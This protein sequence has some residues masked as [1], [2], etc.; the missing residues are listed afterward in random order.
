MA[1]VRTFKL[2]APSGDIGVEALGSS[3]RL[4]V[5]LRCSLAEVLQ[6]ACSSPVCQR[7][8]A[9]LGRHVSGPGAAP[10]WRQAAHPHEY[11]QVTC[12]TPGRW[13]QQ[14]Q[15]QQEAAQPR[16]RALASDS[17]DLQ[18]RGSGAQVV[19]P[20]RAPKPRGCQGRPRVCGRHTCHS[21]FEF[22][23]GQLCCCCVLNC[24]L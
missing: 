23:F 11:S 20:G 7:Q 22:D 1:Q 15:Q 13:E 4:A 10:A 12:V 8:C 18:G 2:K 17:R 5:G 19:L 6:R 9:R 21:F 14:E 24:D 3:E 16:H